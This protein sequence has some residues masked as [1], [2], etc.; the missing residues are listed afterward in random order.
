MLQGGRIDDDWNVDVDRNLSDSWTGFTK[1]TPLCENPLKR[2]HVVRL[3]K[4]QATTRPDHLWPKM[5]SGM[6]KAAQRMEK[7]QWV[8]EKSK[9]HSARKL[10][11][12]YFVDPDDG[13]FKETITKSTEKVGD[14][15]GGGYAL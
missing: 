13:E 2:I 5:W 6:S 7:Q 14:T 4:I 9:L 8:I 11:G 15:D 10:R 12:I 1:F 3:A